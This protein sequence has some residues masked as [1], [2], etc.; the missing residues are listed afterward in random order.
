VF[1]AENVV[2]K[3]RVAL[4]RIEKV[5]S[6][7]SREYEVLQMVQGSPNVVKIEVRVG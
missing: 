5:S 6:A 3:R 7:L 4:K 1:E 2:T